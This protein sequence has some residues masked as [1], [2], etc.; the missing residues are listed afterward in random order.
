MGLFSRN[1]TAVPPV[2]AGEASAS[3]LIAPGTGAPEAAPRPAVVA[4]PR[5]SIVAPA[6]PS[7][8]QIYMG[9]LKVKIHQ[10]LVERLDAVSYTHLTLP[11]KA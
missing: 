2:S 4:P 1:T 10:Q 5:P 8:R 9:Q 11:T 6:P 7:E 3:K